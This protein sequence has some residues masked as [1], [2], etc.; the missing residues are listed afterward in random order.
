DI[1]GCHQGLQFFADRVAAM[2]E[3]H[4]VLT[5][6]GRVALGV[7]RSVEENGLFCD[8]D[9]VAARH[10]GPIEDTRFAFGD[11][12]QLRSLVVDA[13]FTDVRVEAASR[14]VSFGV[15]PDVLARINARGAVGMS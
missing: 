13:G 12:E 8:L 1:A 10:V 3:I 7:W 4:R 5:A 14:E 9:A 15:V 6:G 2:R 11:I